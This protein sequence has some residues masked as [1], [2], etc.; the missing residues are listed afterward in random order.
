MH[1]E[2]PLPLIPFLYPYII[3]PLPE[4]HFGEHFFTSHIVD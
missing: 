1:R 3:E 4:I 2:R